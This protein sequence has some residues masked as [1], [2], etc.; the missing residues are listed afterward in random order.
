MDEDAERAWILARAQVARR[1]HEARLA[2]LAR[3]AEERRARESALVQQAA[4]EDAVE[5]AIARALARRKGP[6]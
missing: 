2:R 3:E 1:R 6:P 4:S 5:A